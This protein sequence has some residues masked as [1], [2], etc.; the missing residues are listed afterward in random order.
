MKQIKE[1]NFSAQK[2]P[3]SPPT[4]SCLSHTRVSAWEP[5]PERDLYLG[6]PLSGTM[7]KLSASSKI[8]PLAC[9]ASLVLGPDLVHLVVEW[10][11]TEC[12][13]QRK[14]TW[15]LSNQPMLLQ[16]Q[17]ATLC[18]L[19]SASFCSFNLQ[20]IYQFL[21]FFI[22]LEVYDLL[23]IFKRN[24]MAFSKKKKLLIDL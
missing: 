18:S 12:M 9:L 17:K 23:F 22:L 6:R 19:S 14:F 20:I 11:V 1:E 24:N 2:F 3:P 8:A 15:D 4:Y 21:V 10:S 13:K 16:S 5:L 7:N